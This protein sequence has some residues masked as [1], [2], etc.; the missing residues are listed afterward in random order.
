MYLRKA[1][2]LKDHTFSVPW[3]FFKTGIFFFFFFFF[4]LGRWN[5]WSA[6]A[7][8]STGNMNDID[9]S[10]FKLHFVHVCLWTHERSCI[11]VNYKHFDFLSYLLT[12]HAMLRAISIFL[13]E[14]FHRTWQVE[15]HSQQI[16]WFPFAH[17]CQLKYQLQLKGSMHLF[18]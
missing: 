6:F 7:F 10:A 4:W 13:C 11:K 14:G 3:V 1:P 17:K 5:L 2:V 8:T 15:G 9:I 18:W 16:I 12:V